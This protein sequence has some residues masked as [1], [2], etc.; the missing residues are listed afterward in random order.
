MFGGLGAKVE[1]FGGIQGLGF[2][3]SKETSSLTFGFGV[4]ELF[5]VRV[6]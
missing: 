3:G 2:R 6:G 4:V 5:R 1:G